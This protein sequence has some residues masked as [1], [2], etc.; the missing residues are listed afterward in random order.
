MLFWY[1]SEKLRKELG[2]ERLVFFSLVW[3]IFLCRTD[4]CRFHPEP[5]G[6]SAEIGC[7]SAS[8]PAEDEVIPPLPLVVAGKMIPKGAITRLREEWMRNIV[9]LP[10]FRQSPGDLPITRRELQLDTA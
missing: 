8:S 4:V 9:V 5:N 7:I 10:R 3:Y 2:N 6:T 1:H